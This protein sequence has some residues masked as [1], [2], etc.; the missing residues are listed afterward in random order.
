M[1][2]TMIIHDP[3]TY[4]RYSDCTPATLRR[5]GGKFLTRGEPVTTPEG[6]EFAERMVIPE[7]PDRKSAEAWYDDPDYQRLCEFRQAASGGG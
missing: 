5:Y 2:C 3:K 7:F 4:R 1:V 6:R